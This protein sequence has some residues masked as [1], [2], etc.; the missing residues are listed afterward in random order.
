M[1]LKES[2]CVYKRESVFV[3][4]RKCVS[5]SVYVVCERERDSVGVS[6]RFLQILAYLNMLTHYK[7]G[8]IILLFGF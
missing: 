7:Y 2:E 1:C 6:K 3:C 5:E 8:H 4:V